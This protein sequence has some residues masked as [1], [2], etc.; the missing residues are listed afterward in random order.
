M[1]LKQYFN[2]FDNPAMRKQE[3]AKQLAVSAG[4]VRVWCSRR[5]PDARIMEVYQATKGVVTPFDM[6]P[7]KYP[8]PTQILKERKFRVKE[9]EEFWKPFKI[10]ECPLCHGAFRLAIEQSPKKRSKH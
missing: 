4:A 7:E 1:K 3:F 10:L 8:K 5:V 9:Q 6:S 2:R